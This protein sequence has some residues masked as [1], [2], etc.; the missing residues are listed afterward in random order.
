MSDLTVLRADRWLDIDA[1][2]VRSPA[3]IVVQGNRITAVNPSSV[4]ASSADVDLGDVTL[5]PGLMDMELNL[6]IGGPENPDGLPNPFHGVTDDP[7]YRILRSTVN[8]RSRSRRP[9]RGHHRHQGRP[10]RDEGRADLQGSLSAALTG[11]R[12][13]GHYHA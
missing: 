12:P 2:Q 5:L 6:C 8:A 3:V 9:F 4:P 10:V 13:F 1:G 7:A 11:A